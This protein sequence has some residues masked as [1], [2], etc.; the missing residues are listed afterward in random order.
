VKRQ[1]RQENLIETLRLRM[2][3]LLEKNK[4]YGMSFAQRKEDF[5]FEMITLYKGYVHKAVE[6]LEDEQVQALET[7]YVGLCR[8]SGFEPPMSMEDAIAEYIDVHGL[9]AIGKEMKDEVLKALTYEDLNAILE[10]VNS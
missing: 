5:M 10:T 9:S 8:G 2:R 1:I 6:R 4:V 3:L 7:K